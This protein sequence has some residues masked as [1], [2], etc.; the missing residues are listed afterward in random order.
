[1]AIRTRRLVAG[2]FAQRRKGAKGC[3]LCAF[4]SLREF[5]KHE[6][7]ASKHNVVYLNPLMLPLLNPWHKATSNFKPCSAI[8][9]IR[10][11]FFRDFY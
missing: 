5:F 3:F 7:T 10:H 8:V 9:Q 1:M 6:P 2:I 4:A 11:V